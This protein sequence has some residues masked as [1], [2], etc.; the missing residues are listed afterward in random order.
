MIDQFYTDKRVLD[1]LHG[2]PLGPY[3]NDFTAW[4]SEQ[5][6]AKFTITYGIR[7]IGTLNCWMQLR[8]LSVTDLDEKI[9]ADFFRDRRSK[10]RIQLA[11]IP[12]INLFLKHLRQSHVIPV[13]A[14]EVDNSELGGI[15]RSFAD[16]LSKERRLSEASLQNYVPVVRQF[17]EERF[18]S[19]PIMFKEIQQ[20]DISRFVLRYANRFNRARAK[21]MVS[22]LRSFLRFLHLYG[23]ISTDLASVVP[24]VANWQCATLPNWIPPEDVEHLLNSCDQSTS[25]GQRDYAI[26]LLLARLGLR[27]GEVVNMT[28]DDID[29]EAGEIRVSGKS[30][31]HDRLPLPK[32]VGEALAKY[33]C[34]GRPRRC[35]TRRVFVR[36]RAP[37]RGLMGRGAIYSM[38]QR[39]FDR[40]ELHPS[41]KGP[42][43]LRHSL[44]TNMLRKGASLSEIGQILRHRDLATT[45]IY[46]KV[47]LEAL[48]KIAQPWPGG[49]Q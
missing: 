2:G 22:A 30:R 45:Q 35:S 12:K 36:M 31:R 43:T 20:I 33:L 3:I 16:Y 28:L 37:L 21:I 26:L 10:R 25:T 47:D 7:L 14:V 29:W 5:G 42:H 15:V 34:Q 44:A 19:E 18:G 9:T 48:S 39:A 13:P 11:D 24:T 40:A 4:L 17:L 38:V 49:E 41:H 27:S 8:D 1:R 6:Y 32:D 46:A 23:Y